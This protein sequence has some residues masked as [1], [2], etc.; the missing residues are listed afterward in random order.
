MIKTT[1]V[2]AALLSS[3]AT[4]SADVITLYCAPKGYSV[5]GITVTVD[6]AARTVN[7]WRC[8]TFTEYEINCGFSLPL[9]NITIVSSTIVLNRVT[10]ALIMISVA[11]HIWETEWS[12][13]SVAYFDCSTNIPNPRF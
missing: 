8:R 2:V 10:G 9:D 4:A 13:P 5:T 1:M 12:G 7:G 6:S 3:V 11:K